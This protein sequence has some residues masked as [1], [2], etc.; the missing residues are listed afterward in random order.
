MQKLE[1]CSDGEVPGLQVLSTV[2]K[3]GKLRL[4]GTLSGPEATVKI[5][6]IMAGMLLN[7]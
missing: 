3:G 6:D 2:K 4:Y 1:K 5:R 7:L